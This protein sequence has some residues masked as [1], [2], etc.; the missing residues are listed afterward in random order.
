MKE[1]INN[2]KSS[3]NMRT[4]ILLYFI[5]TFI[6][7][8]VIYTL[9][10]PIEYLGFIY[11]N[12]TGFIT[13]SFLY[14]YTTYVTENLYKVFSASHGFA[15]LPFIL[16]I[17]CFYFDNK[18]HMNDMTYK[19]VMKKKNDSLRLANIWLSFTIIFL[20]IIV[21]RN[22]TDMFLNNDPYYLLDDEVWYGVRF[23]IFSYFF[24]IFLA[25]RYAILSNF[26]NKK[27]SSE[28]KDQ[29]DTEND[30]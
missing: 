2:T 24:L 16:Y 18:R 29:G 8:S 30:K 7:Y 25:I 14:P 11:H 27:Q 5:P 13:G 10:N 12:I 19:D 26:C 4:L 3:F 1:N 17:F 9:D 20:V 23:V 28:I 15:A 21:C 6:I 22:A